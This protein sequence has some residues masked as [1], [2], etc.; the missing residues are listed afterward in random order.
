MHEGAY[1]KWGLLF[2]RNRKTEKLQGQ[3]ETTHVN[4]KQSGKGRDS[5]C[6]GAPAWRSRERIIEKVTAKTGMKSRESW[7]GKGSGEMLRRQ[8]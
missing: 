8:K 7:I 2:Y 3:K 4:L 1:K 5:N 6:N